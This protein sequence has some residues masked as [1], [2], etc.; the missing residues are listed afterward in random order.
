MSFLS[1]LDLLTVSGSEQDIIRCLVRRPDLT[2]SEI[3]KFTRIP[4]D[5]LERLLSSMVQEARLIQDDKERFQVSYGKEE[6][7]KQTRSGTGL[8]D[9]LFGR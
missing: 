6:K 2:M 9:T 8:L 4:L 5:E 7:A 1:P 3:A